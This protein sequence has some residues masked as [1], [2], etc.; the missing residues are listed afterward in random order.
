MKPHPYHKIFSFAAVI[1]ILALSDAESGEARWPEYPV[2]RGT[3]Y[4]SAGQETGLEFKR[5]AEPSVSSSAR[6]LSPGAS[7]DLEVTGL[8]ASY[9]CRAVSSRGD[10]VYAALGKELQIIDC[11]DPSSP[12]VLGVLSCPEVIYNLMVEG[13]Y[14]YVADGDSGLRIIDI[15]NPLSPSE[16]GFCPT[17]DFCFD[18]SVSG[19]FACVADADSGLM[20]VDISNPSSP[21][22]TE[23][24]DTGGITF[25]VTSDGGYAYA[26]DNTGGLLVIDI[27]DPSTPFP[28]R[29]MPDRRHRC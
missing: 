23:S 22:S 9:P 11:S 12:R 5:R 13:D 26:A 16:T 15:S 25:G 3:N 20:V 17:A 18:V 21:Y 19:N 1:L 8:F 7:S 2:N 10:T 14:A 28:V 6:Y 27:S 24:Y 4:Y 29:F